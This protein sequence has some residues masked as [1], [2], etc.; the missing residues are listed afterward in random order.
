M[1]HLLARDTDLHNQSNLATCN[2]ENIN[3]N[4][5]ATETLRQILFANRDTV[6]KLLYHRKST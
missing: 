6:F 2:K 3:R 5:R 1:L 4:S